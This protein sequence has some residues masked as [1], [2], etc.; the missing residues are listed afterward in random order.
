MIIIILIMIILNIIYHISGLLGILT[1]LVW[2]INLFMTT[3]ILIRDPDNL[4][5]RIIQIISIFLL[6]YIIFLNINMLY[7]SFYKFAL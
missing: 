7:N 6:M 3:M 4:W 1:I 5:I 2:T